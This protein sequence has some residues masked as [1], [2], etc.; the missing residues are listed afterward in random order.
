MHPHCGSGE[1]CYAGGLMGLCCEAAGSRQLPVV[2]APTFFRPPL[3][4]LRRLLP[5]CCTCCGTLPAPLHLVTRSAPHRAPLLPSSP[6][7][8]RRPVP[9]RRARGA[10]GRL[11]LPPHRR[12]QASGGHCHR[13]GGVSIVRCT[14]TVAALQPCG[15]AVHQHARRSA[16][17]RPRRRRHR[18]LLTCD[19]RVCLIDNHA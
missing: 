17:P 1:C 6:L 3:I 7:P 11:P 10:A 9:G 15:C 13:L 18:L 8:C 16:A 19:A 2:P 4:K 12:R 5:H 14:C